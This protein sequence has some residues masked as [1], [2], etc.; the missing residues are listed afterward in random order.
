MT[1]RELS[2]LI[3]RDPTLSRIMSSGVSRVFA[4]DKIGMSSDNC[5]TCDPPF[6]SRNFYE[7]FARNQRR[8]G[9]FTEIRIFP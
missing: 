6:L 1:G 9:K 3:D 5:C 2:A 7:T 4:K 8:G